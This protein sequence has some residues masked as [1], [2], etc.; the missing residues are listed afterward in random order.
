MNNKMNE[1]IIAPKDLTVQTPKFVIIE[2]YFGMSKFPIKAI[3]DFSKVPDYLHEDFVN[4]IYQMNFLGK[5]KPSKP[6]NILTKLVNI[7]FRYP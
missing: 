6:P 7:L 2:D 5:S 4:I 1:Y 3:F